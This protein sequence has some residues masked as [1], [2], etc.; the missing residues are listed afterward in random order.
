MK[1]L[2]VEKLPVTKCKWHLPINPEFGYLPDSF[3]F[4]L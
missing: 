3:Y 1:A 4:R 2:K